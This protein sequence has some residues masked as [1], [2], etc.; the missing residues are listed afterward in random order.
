MLSAATQAARAFPQ[1][2]EFSEKHS[3]RTVNCAM[4]HLSD[5]GPAGDGPGQTGSLSQDD[6]NQLNKARTAM[7]PGS[8]VTNPI[9]NKF[10]NEIIRAI[11]MKKFLELMPDPAKL[12]QAL[13]DK[14]DLDGDGISDGQEFLDGTDPLNKYHGDPLKLFFINLNRCKFELLLIAVAVLFLDYG[15]ANL[16]AGAS[17]AAKTNEP[18]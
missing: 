10:G 3:G 13:G 14:S 16:V 12:P 2:Q 18:K 9:L 1:Y 5:D 11:G 6:L 15:L 17:S 8:T 4:C 7:E